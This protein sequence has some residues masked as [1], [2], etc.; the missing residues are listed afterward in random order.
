MKVKVQKSKVGCFAE[1]DFPADFC[2]NCMPISFPAIVL[3][4][5]DEGR[6]CINIYT[7]LTE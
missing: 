6:Q 1:P 3:F 2:T 7:I 5:R 4:R